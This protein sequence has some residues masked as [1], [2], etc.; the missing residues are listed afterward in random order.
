MGATLPAIS[1]WV[2]ATPDGVAWLGFFY[3]GNIGGGVIGSL[4]A[5]FYLLRVFDVATATAVAVAINI[6][7]FAIA[8]LLARRTTYE[9]DEPVLATSS[10]PGGIW[11][12]YVAIALSG[13]TALSAEVI[14]TRLLLL[15]FGA[16]VY[17]FALILAVFL[18][19]L[20]IGSTV[21]ASIGRS[22]ASPRRA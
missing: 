14:W 7:V 18:I 20:G 21:G 9:P 19:G 1:R 10:R 11:P 17:T 8:G 2:K 12:V 13:T 16:T 22:A 6:A 15:H 4:A 3:G 5:G